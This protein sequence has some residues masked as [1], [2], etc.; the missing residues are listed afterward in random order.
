MFARIVTAIERSPIGFHVMNLLVASIWAWFV[1][2]GLS[3]FQTTRALALEWPYDFLYETMPLVAAANSGLLVVFFVLRR[4]TTEVG[5]DAL[6]IVLAHLGTWLPLLPLALPDRGPPVSQ[7][8]IL[9]ASIVLLVSLGVSFLGFASLGRSW[10]IIPANRGI[11]RRGLYRIVRH[12]IYANYM[13]FYLVQPLIRFDW[14]TLTVAVGLPI[15]L[16]ARAFL[17]ER[18]LRRDPAYVEFAKETRYMFFPGLI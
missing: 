18:L 3:S 2:L 1:Y 10:G 4:R 16:A 17:E 8:V 9:P 13:V 12:P 5:G 15:L 14:K 6:S 7:A 11:Q